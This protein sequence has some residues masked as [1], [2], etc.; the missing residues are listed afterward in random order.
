MG[1]TLSVVVKGHGG[2]MPVDLLGLHRLSSRLDQVHFEGSRQGGHP[3]VNQ[4]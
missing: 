2:R 3:S 1:V 4:H